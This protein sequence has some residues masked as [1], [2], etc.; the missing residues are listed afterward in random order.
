MAAEGF[1]N[2]DA[3]VGAPAEVIHLHFGLGEDVGPHAFDQGADRALEL[4]LG[5]SG[6]GGG[7]SGLEVGGELMRSDAKG[8]GDIG[9]KRHTP[10]SK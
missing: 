6:E 7:E 9:R 2:H 5:L 10:K 3:D 8:R 1:L 4:V